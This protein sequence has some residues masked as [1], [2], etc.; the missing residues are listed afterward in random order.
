V[1]YTSELFL[2]IF[3]NIKQLNENSTE[4]TKNIATCDDIGRENSA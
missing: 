2:A 1:K 3:I 4:K